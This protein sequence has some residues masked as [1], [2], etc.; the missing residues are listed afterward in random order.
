MSPRAIGNLVDRFLNS[1]AP[2]D[3]ANLSLR[4]LGRSLYSDFIDDASKMVHRPE[5][6]AILG[7]AGKMKHAGRSLL[8]VGG[9]DYA[10]PYARQIVEAPTEAVLL[11]VDRNVPFIRLSSMAM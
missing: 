7:T 3:Q 8:V 6:E 11:I 5:A 1:L 4:R 10:A 9:N 2:Y